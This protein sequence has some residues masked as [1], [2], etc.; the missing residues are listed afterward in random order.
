MPITRGM[1]DA[2]MRKLDEENAVEGTTGAKDAQTALYRQRMRIES[3]RTLEGRA[4]SVRAS[5]G[6]V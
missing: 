5:L 3:L 1:V 2:R 4:G 6:E